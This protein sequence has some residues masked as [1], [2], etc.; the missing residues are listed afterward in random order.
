MNVP[1][2]MNARFNVYLMHM[3]SWIREG[4]QL[5]PAQLARLELLAKGGV[6]EPRPIPSAPDPGA[7]PP[8]RDVLASDILLANPPGD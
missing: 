4:Y 3:E 1:P 8:E 6:I 5:T 2:W 7:G